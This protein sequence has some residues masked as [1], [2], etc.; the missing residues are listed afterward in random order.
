VDVETAK[1]QKLQEVS[2]PIQSSKPKPVAVIDPAASEEV[3]VRV[4]AVVAPLVS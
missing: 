3:V 1:E 4:V 2:R